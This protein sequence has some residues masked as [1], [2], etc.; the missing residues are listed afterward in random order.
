MGLYLLHNSGQ[1]L[2]SVLPPLCLVCLYLR[3]TSLLSCGL[4]LW[5]APA[6]SVVY[7][8]SICPFWAPN[9]ISFLFP[10][11]RD[12]S[13][14]QSINQ[15]SIN[16]TSKQEVTQIFTR[17]AH[18]HARSQLAQISN[19]YFLHKRQLSPMGVKYGLWLR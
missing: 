8:E 3:P 9:F 17:C 15:Q 4:F 11:G 2:Y 5:G 6:A 13:I 14:N 10:I 12:Q 16:I 7:I 18:A 1:P 19:R